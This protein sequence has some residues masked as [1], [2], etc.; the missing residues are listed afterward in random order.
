MAG[1]LPQE[2]L[3]PETLDELCGSQDDKPFKPRIMYTRVPR[4]DLIVTKCNGAK[5][6]MVHPQ[7]QML[8]R[9]FVV[10]QNP[11]NIVHRQINPF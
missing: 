3:D 10:E 2:M 5:I 1:L 4:R 6:P 7:I 9:G 8:H 11:L